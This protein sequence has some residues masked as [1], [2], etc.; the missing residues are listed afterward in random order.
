MLDARLIAKPGKGKYI[1]QICGVLSLVFSF[2][3]W[4]TIFIFHKGVQIS[5]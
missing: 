3:L 5:A 1:K 4:Y 2:I